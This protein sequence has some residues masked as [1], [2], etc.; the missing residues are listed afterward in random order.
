M[1]TFVCKVCG[2]VAFDQ[3]PVE[4]PV[5]GAAIENFENDSAAVRKPLDAEHLT[6]EEKAHIPVAS[7]HRD[8]GPGLGTECID[9]HIQVGEI[10]HVMESE[11][12]IQFIDFYVSKKF[13]ARIVLTPKRIYPA[14]SVR[15]NVF[16]GTL[17][18][19]A[20]C[21]VHGNWMTRIKLDE[22]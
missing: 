19:L 21:N 9:V 4:C 16:E 14:A 20:G 11:H 7:I 10:E 8:C 13:L 5:C 1:K 15:I 12:F 18:V 6:G 2:H 17:T 3:A 22:E